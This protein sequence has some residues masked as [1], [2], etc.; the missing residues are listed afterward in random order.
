MV[1]K[2]IL[3]AITYPTKKELGESLPKRVQYQTFNSILDCLENSD[4][5]IL[6]RA[7]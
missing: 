5:I 1:E 6:T 7:R 4:M 2:Y 3:K